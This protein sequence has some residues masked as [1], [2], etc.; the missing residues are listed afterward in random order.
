[1]V[2]LC[3]STVTCL[4]ALMFR[5]LFW[6]FSY[7]LCCRISFFTLC[8]KPE[9][10]LLWLVSWPALLWLVNRS[11]MSRPLAYHAQWVGALANI[12]ASLSDVSISL[13]E[14]IPASVPC[15]EGLSDAK[16][17]RFNYSLYIV[18][19]YWHCCFR[20]AFWYVA[21]ICFAAAPVLSRT[22]FSF[23]AVTPVYI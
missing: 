21:Y 14:A 2:V 10:S 19:L 8:L 18:H 6:F 12:S 20:K 9:P 16:V 13:C 23:C 17:K 3:F 22:L 4:H 1:M 11:E 5:K 7:C 15:W